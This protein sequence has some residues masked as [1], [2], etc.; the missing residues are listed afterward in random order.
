MFIH[1]YTR[2]PT[3]HYIQIESGTPAG[4]LHGIP[5]V[6]HHGAGHAVWHV[7]ADGTGELD[8]VLQLHRRREVHEV[9]VVEV[10][11]LPRFRFRLEHETHVYVC[12]VVC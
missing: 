4:T 1:T 9:Q 10:D 8:K 2:A 12:T 3:H 7:T 5:A 6:D 11:Y